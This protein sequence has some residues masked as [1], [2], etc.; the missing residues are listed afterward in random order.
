MDDISLDCSRMLS[1]PTVD[2]RLRGVRLLADLRPL[3]MDLYRCAFADQDWRVRKEAV[4]GFLSS[5]GVE[6]Y[7]GTIIELLRDPENAGLRNSSIEILVSLGPLV[8]ENLIAEM[9]CPDADVRKFVIDILGEIGSP[10]CIE[11]VLN[12]LKDEDMNVL[13][14]AVETLGKLSVTRAIG[15]LL[16]LMEDADT[17]LRFTILEALT[18]IGEDVSIA[19]LRQYLADRVLRKALL[20]CFGRIGGPEVLPYLL[21]GLTDPMRRVREVSLRSLAHRAKVM[22][23][24]IRAALGAA[25][26]DL[27]VQLIDLLAAG[28]NASRRDAI[29][30]TALVGGLGVAQALL[31]LLQEEGLREEVIAAFHDQDERFFD[32]LLTD[33]FCCEPRTRLSLVYLAGE[34]SR[35]AGRQLAIDS[36]ADADPELR[37]AAVVA[38]GKIGDESAVEPLCALLQDEHPQICDA[39]ASALE[40]L[41]AE[42]HEKVVG[43]LE[44]LM[45]ATDAALRTR[46]V[47]VL[48]RVADRGLEPSLLMALKDPEPAVRCEAI[49]ALGRNR[50]GLHGEGLKLALNDEVADV[51]RLAAEAL[52][53]THERDALPAL[54]LA[55]E[56]PDPWVRAAAVR[57]LGTFAGDQ[58]DQLLVRMLEDQVGLVVIAALEALARRDAS[59]SLA[60]LEGALLHHDEEVV[61]AAV[62]LLL[63]QGDLCGRLLDHADEKVRMHAVAA[64][65]RIHGRAGL[66]SLEQ[67]LRVETEPVVRKALEDA[68]N[69]LQ[70]SVG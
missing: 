60:S 11:G 45:A 29:R 30:L 34:L 5:P 32:Q 37:Y 21:E 69:H 31:P 40:L 70:R 25:P 68:L 19:R 9:T 6:Q 49:R 63:R 56:D 10:E 59:R 8:V 17:G 18:A 22:P 2:D 38:L 7:A 55:V 52:G 27:T 12:A 3:R 48:G 26:D 50:S 43:L 51:R 54:M 4:R 66:P 58:V 36:L 20:D 65:V 23:A 14:A 1:G 15:P 13:Y 64:I 28:D 62:D 67:R 46:V 53:R 33:E 44:S 35:L 39:A 47:R 16:D 61:R 42:H 24:E 57:S 41:G